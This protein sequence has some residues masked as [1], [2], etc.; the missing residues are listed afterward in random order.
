MLFYLGLGYIKTGRFAEAERFGNEL[1]TVLTGRQAPQDRSFGMAHLVVAEALL[2]EHRYRDALPHARIAA[3]L[4]SQ[5]VRSP[6]GKAMR[7]EAV[8]LV[9]SVDSALRESTGPR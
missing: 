6:Y 7:A 3:D 5:G 4:L 2:G 1:L 8:D 9:K